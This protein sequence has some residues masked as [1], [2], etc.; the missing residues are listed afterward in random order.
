[1]STSSKIIYT[2]TDESPAMATHSFLPVIKAFTHPAQIEVEKR[3]ISLAGRILAVFPEYLTEAQRVQDDLHY[4]GELAKTPEA[5]I[6][7]LPNISASLPQLNAAIKELQEKG[8]AIPDYPS[9]PKNEKEE[10]IKNRYGKVSGSAV[11]PVLRE[12][13]SDRRAPKAVKNYTKKHQHRIATW[14]KEIKN[15]YVKVTGSAVNPFL[16]EGNRDR[17]APKAVKNY[18]K[19]HPQ[20]MGAWS[21]DSKTHVATMSSGDF[22]HNEKSMTMPSDDVLSIVFTSD[23]GS[24]KTL[25][26]DLKVLKDEIIDA[27]VM[28]SKALVSFLEN[29]I[30][31]AKEHDILFSAHLKAT[32][33]KV[34]DPI[35]FGYVVKTYFA[36]LFKKYQDTFQKLDINPNDVLTVLER[37]LKN[38]LDNER[39]AI[40]ADIKKIMD[41]NPD[42]AMVDSDKGITNLHMPNDVIIDASMPAMI[43]NS[44]KMWG[45]DGKTY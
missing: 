17:R 21:K 24:K 42:L 14:S 29:A 41:E 22:F 18:A 26:K 34:S 23:S 9:N 11:N 13:N 5:N 38:L 6:I 10:E 45:P 32:M 7:K 30:Q 16:R 33:M 25:K 37:K 40:E 28:S 36:D 1:M 31:D 2:K 3:D 39:E 44:G 19:K 15:R 27:T 35:I 43:R 20:R 4:L 12:G 8:Y